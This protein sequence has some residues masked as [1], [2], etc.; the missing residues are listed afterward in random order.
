MAKIVIKPFE[1]DL[2]KNLPHRYKACTKELMALGVRRLR[3][4]NWEQCLARPPSS[5]REMWCY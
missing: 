5:Y 4:E 1:D 3:L 2:D